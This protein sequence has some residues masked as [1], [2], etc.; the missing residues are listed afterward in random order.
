[1]FI[2]AALLAALQPASPGFHWECS[3]GTEDGGGLL[4]A[5]RRLDANG[6][7]IDDHLRWHIPQ[8]DGLFGRI[9]WAI[10]WAAPGAIR[11]W[12]MWVRIGLSRQ[13]AGPMWAIVRADGRELSRVA[14][15]VPRL[16][17]WDERGRTLLML[18]YRT[19]PA[20]GMSDPPTAPMPSLGEAREVDILIEEA[21]GGATL[22]RLHVPMP[23]WGRLSREIG[24]LRTAL[25][26]D[27]SAYR[28][29][30]RDVVTPIRVELRRVP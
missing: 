11:A 28:Q 23:D 27:V 4:L 14:V 21:T 3:R 12:S 6:R 1:M 29:R 5:L 2:A 20:P 19:G 24:L 8:T 16:R 30:C 9:E 17:S 18:D 26:E 13:P 25:G 22:A 10:E 15:E 7:V